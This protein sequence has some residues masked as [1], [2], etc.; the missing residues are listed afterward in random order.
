MASKD[1]HIDC[2]FNAPPAKVFESVATQ[3]GIAGWWTQLCQVSKKAGEKAFFLFPQSD[4][5]AVMKIAERHPPER[6]EWEC[7][8]CKHPDASGLKNLHDWAGTRV[9]FEIKPAGGGKSKLHFTH[10]GLLGV[11]SG[12]VCADIWTFFL[13][14]SL[15]AYLE[16]GTGEPAKVP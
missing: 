10:A 13:N 11:A 5:Y 2:E 15:R 14:K 12:P 1:F 4:F 6:L 7:E 3:E 16:T 9:I 8:D